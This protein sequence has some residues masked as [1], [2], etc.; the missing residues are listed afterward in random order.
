MV[1]VI[2]GLVAILAIMSGLLQIAGLTRAHTAVLVEARREAGQAALLGLGS[3]P[4]LSAP[5]YIMDWQE[6]LDGKRLTRD[7]TFTMAS[8]VPFDDGI[9]ERAAPDPQGWELLHSVPE[10]ALPRLHNHANPVSL[11]GLVRGH[12]EACV[13]L[14]PAVQHL[15]YAADTIEVESEVWMTWTRGIY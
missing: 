11:F 1:E 3:G 10:D 6:G 7:D 2:V 14:L 15:L 12:A 9:V 8:S 4:P 5:H 13:P